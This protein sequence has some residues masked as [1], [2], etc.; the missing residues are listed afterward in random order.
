MA[1]KATEII[2]STSAAHFPSQSL[3]IYYFHTLRGRGPNHIHHTLPGNCSVESHVALHV[4]CLC[5]LHASG[6]L[7]FKEEAGP[8]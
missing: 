4:S 8:S 5:G 7:V 2:H 3:E 1:H 6:L